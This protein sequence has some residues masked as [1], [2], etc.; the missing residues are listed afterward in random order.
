[1]ALTR[2]FLSALGIED[3]KAE[4]II[5]AHLET[6]N[7]LKQ[8]RDTLKVDAE[9]LPGVQRE[10][11]VANG[12]LKEY[13]DNDE[14]GSWKSKY[15]TVVSEKQKLQT[16]FDNYKADISAKE[17]TAKKASAYRSLLKQAGI[18]EKRIDSVMKVSDMKAIELEDDGTIK[19]AK[20]LTKTIKTEWADFIGTTQTHGASVS[21]PPENNGG[22]AGVNTRAA[23]IAKAHY[24]RI[25]GT[26][27]EESK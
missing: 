7:P 17:L 15:D 2:K 26:N 6:V 14:A 1:M 16:D 22:S 13:E 10:L 4:Q 24:A 8:E 20:E 11:D 27:A 3:D 9:K 12:K 25:Y 23:E 21:N 18:S 5:T 19:D